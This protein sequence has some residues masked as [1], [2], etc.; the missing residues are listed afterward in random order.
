MIEPKLIKIEAVDEPDV[1]PRPDAGD[2]PESTLQPG[3]VR[4]FWKRHASSWPSR[5]V[6]ARSVR[7]PG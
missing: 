1:C 7:S 4:R 6:L 5:V 2:R 3:S